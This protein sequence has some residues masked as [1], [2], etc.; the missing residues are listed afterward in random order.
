MKTIVTV[1]FQKK[2]GQAI[3]KSANAVVENDWVLHKTVI[4]RLERCRCFAKKPRPKEH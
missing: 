2:L 1:M 4:E 3:A